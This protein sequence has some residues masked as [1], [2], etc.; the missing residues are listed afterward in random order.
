MD[1]RFEQTLLYDFYGELLTEHQKKIYEAV[2]FEDLSYAE[3]AD[4]F[5]VSRQAVHDNVRRTEAMLRSYEEKLGL[6]DR[7][8]KTKELVKEINHLAREFGKTGDAESVK[9]IAAL[10]EE[11]G[12]L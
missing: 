2:I 5:S 11:I 10:S 4:L 6:V 9:K 1:K 8:V 12:E 7:F 3:A